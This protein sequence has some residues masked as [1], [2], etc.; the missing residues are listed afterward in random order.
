MYCVVPLAGPDLYSEK[1][2]VFKPM[3]PYNQGRLLSEIL[4]NRSWYVEVEKFIFV[5]LEQPGINELKKWL[6]HEFSNSSILMVSSLTQG[7]LLSA[8]AG[9]SLIEN[10]NNPIIFDLADIDFLGDIDPSWIFENEQVGGIVPYFCS[11]LSKFSYL[12][13]DPVNNN[14]IGAVEKHV[15]SEMASAG[16]YIFR[17]THV[18]LESVID[19]IKHRKSYQ[20][21]GILYLCPSM[22]GVIKLGKEVVGRK[23]E[24]AV[25]DFNS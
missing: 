25:W 13:Q 14:I 17:D 16:V 10:F 18:F 6:E 23:V 12:I 22:N 24:S 5:L 3:L 7:A 20:Y 2:Q 1:F 8:L 4:K 11:N 19:S 9:I 21:N 15:A